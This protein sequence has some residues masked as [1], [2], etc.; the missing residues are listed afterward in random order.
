MYRFVSLFP[1]PKP[2]RKRLIRKLRRLIN[3]RNYWRNRSIRPRTRR[4]R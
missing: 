1:A 4:P 2:T 3:Q